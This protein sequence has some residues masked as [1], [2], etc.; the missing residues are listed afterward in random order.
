MRPETTFEAIEESVAALNRAFGTAEA[1][2]VLD[3][4]LQAFGGRIA[5][6]S[7]FGAESVVL[8]H[9]VSRL[10]PALPVLFLD[11]EMLFA[12]TLA[13]QRELAERLGLT[14]VRV[15][16]PA[17]DLVERSDPLGDLH[18]RDPDLCCQI[19]KTAPLDAALGRYAA[20]IT[21][22]KRHQT[23]ARAGLAAFEADAAGRIKINPLH[24]WSGADLARYI[25]AHAL[26][27]HP[28]VAQGYPS[29]GC[30]PCTSPVHPDE[31]PRAGRWRG[32]EK[33][34][35]GIHFVNGRAVRVAPHE[36]MEDRN[37]R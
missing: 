36:A 10:D 18:R 26:P 32:A 23:A 12:E 16:R 6:V 15:L 28:L 13:Y 3:H 33:Q 29:I 20:W 21:G 7:S 24:G 34:E 4:G 5:L 31:D 11:T 30:A 37:D 14:G 22:R 8:L 27:R 25:D 19:R 9:M 1:E 2:A 17:A 35:C